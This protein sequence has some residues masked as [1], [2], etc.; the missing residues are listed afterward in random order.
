MYLKCSEWS[1]SMV[2]S[3]VR[4]ALLA[5]AGDARNQLRHALSELG[6][7]L[8]AEG[9]P[10]EMDQQSVIDKNPKLVLVG[11]EPAIELGLERFD[12]LLS[13][14]DVEVIY[15]DAEV[16][17]GLSGWDLNRWARHLAAKIVGGDDVLPPIPEDAVML[18]ENELQPGPGA[19]PTPAE[20]MQDAK[21]E[22]Y[23]VDTLAMAA[24]VPSNSFVPA[25]AVAE[26]QIEITDT[27]S[28]PVDE[29]AIADFVAPV[30]ESK[31][32]EPSSEEFSIDVSD[33]E[34]A[35][36]RMEFADQDAGNKVLLDESVSSPV[37]ALS[38]DARLDASLNDLMLDESG[39]VI[40]E[41]ALSTET[42]INFNTDE[43]AI[44]SDASTDFDFDDSTPILGD[45]FNTDA[46]VNFSSYDNEDDL[47]LSAELDSDVA[48]LA[49]QMDNLDSDK[50]VQIANDLRFDE[51]A[52]IPIAPTVTQELKVEPA[53]E[54]PAAKIDFS[55]LSLM[56]MDDTSP[57]ASYQPAAVEAPKPVEA[58]APVA[59]ASAAVAA[60]MFDASTLEI[61]Q[62]T[63][64]DADAVVMLLA[65]LGGPD[66][67]RQFISNLNP[68]SKLLV[69]VQQ[70]LEVGSYDR[71]ATQFGK[72]S[73]LPV[74]L[75]QAG[76][77][78][79]AGKCYVVPANMGLKNA[80]GAL[81]FEEGLDEAASMRVLPP[82]RTH[83]LVASG[84]STSLLDTV[85]QF[86]N[87]GGHI[88][89]QPPAECF[90]GEAAQALA[91]DGV[92]TVQP[93]EWPEQLSK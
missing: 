39:H 82:T 29:S 76:A 17:A 61:E 71:L 67:I 85:R 83:V 46:K 57:A 59:P 33:V 68:A 15:D 42:D 41:S 84:A 27:Y 91:N 56:D 64:A 9:D 11:L 14:N 28:D 37:E 45:D 78:A 77:L 3:A 72:V 90:E 26:T 58:P 2:D 62:E 32:L 10:N 6:A 80:N 22:D 31:T 65:G 60:K 52:E 86:R 4:V 23:T 30:V 87:R 66:A 74:V 1:Q 18:S 19:V 7:E 55:S 54:K 81:S 50:P 75:A 13:S 73:K 93:R 35:M 38:I 92:Q 5:K 8:V 44:S 89:I 24:D 63:A 53:I 49:E 43:M 36:Q 16:T 88:R 34:Q 40:E 51:P 70:R 48:A 12:D 47:A 25:E 20:L 21:F 79:E 69:L